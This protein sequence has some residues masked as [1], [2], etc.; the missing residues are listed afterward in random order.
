MSVTCGLNGRC[1][2]CVLVDIDETRP[3]L[4]YRL[5]ITGLF[6][7][8]LAHEQKRGRSD[9]NEPLDPFADRDSRRIAFVPKSEAGREAGFRCPPR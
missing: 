4:P 5:A 6:M 3:R 9:C 1:W 7:A 2:D 8:E